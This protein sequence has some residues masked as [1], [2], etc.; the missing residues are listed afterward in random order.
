[1]EVSNAKKDGKCLRYKYKWQEKK[2]NKSDFVESFIRNYT[3]IE[4]DDDIFMYPK[5][6]SLFH[7]SQVIE[8]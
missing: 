3:K 8:L 2:Y 5:K 6:Y 1:M 4:E 7:I